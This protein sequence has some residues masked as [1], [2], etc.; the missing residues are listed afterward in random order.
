MIATKLHGYA[1]ELHQLT[2]D[3]MEQ[4][5]SW[6]NQPDVRAN[7]L[8]D[9]PI[10]I[11]QHQA[12]F[13]AMLKSDREAHYKIIVKEK[14]I[15]VVNIRANTAL[16]DASEAEIGIYIADNDYK[17]NLVAFSPSLLLIDYA[18]EELGINA[19]G[20]VV[21]AENREALR[22]NEVLGYTLAPTDS[23]GLIKI[24]LT[25]DAYI[26]A[27]KRIKTFLSRS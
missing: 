26:T 17:G 22:Y 15:G 24:R 14:E 4:V 10:A 11:A 6:R 13:S 23:Q 3:D 8:D 21:K 9:K 5:F 20:S 2:H 1:I 12:W 7:M 19:L 18:F 25:P 16:S 27:T